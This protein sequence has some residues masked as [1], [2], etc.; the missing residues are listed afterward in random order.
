M[1]FY[2][3]KANRSLIEVFIE[4]L[5]DKREHKFKV[6]QPERLERIFRSA[7]QLSEYAWIKD[8]FIIKVRP[9]ELWFVVRQIGI[10]EFIE[11]V[12]LISG[13]DFLGITS[14]LLSGTDERYRFV[15]GLGEKEIEKLTNWAT[16][17]NYSIQY[18]DSILEVKKNG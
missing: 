8:T 1:G 12:E 4:R 2:L 5:K 15:V 17:N 18:N 10:E 11:P 6:S 3:S 7:C 13:E 14:I 9:D 16:K